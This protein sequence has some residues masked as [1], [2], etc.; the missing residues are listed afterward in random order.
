MSEDDARFADGDQHVKYRGVCDYCGPIKFDEHPE[1]EFGPECPGCAEV[2]RLV[3]EFP[4]DYEFPDAVDA[5]QL[6][7]AHEM[8]TMLD[9][10]ENDD[11]A[12]VS[13]KVRG[14]L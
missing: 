2:L 8:L 9:D 4:V 7:E 5:D 10:I 14:M 12:T 3:S 1:G 13:E 6:E 11:P